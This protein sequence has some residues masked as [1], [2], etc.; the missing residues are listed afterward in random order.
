MFY[1]PHLIQS[2]TKSICSRYVCYLLHRRHC[3]SIK[4]SRVKLLAMTHIRIL[5]QNYSGMTFPSPSFTSFLLLNLYI[6]LK[7]TPFPFVSH[8]SRRRESTQ[9]T[10]R[11]CIVYFSK[12][13]NYFS[14]D[15]ERFSSPFIASNP[16]IYN[17]ARIHTVYC[18]LYVIAYLFYLYNRARWQ[19][20]FQ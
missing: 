15:R 19:M 11:T 16:V 1:K 7:D 10:A 4:N 14:I 6:Q 13:V 20:F 9:C 5:L 12:T 18:S 8:H 17:A 3:L 2:D